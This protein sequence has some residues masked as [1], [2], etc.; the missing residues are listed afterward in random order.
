MAL[1]RNEE[2][3]DIRIIDRLQR[4]V[5]KEIK[6]PSDQIYNDTRQLRLISNY[7][8]QS[9]PFAI[10]RDYFDLSIVDLIKG[11]VYKLLSNKES[12]G[13]AQTMES[14]WDAEEDKLLIT[15]LNKVDHSAALERYEVSGIFIRAI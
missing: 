3:I 6:R 2:C 15:I 9:Y 5:V 10:I 13:Y 8:S 7:D 4:K 14:K 12:T 11:K 1:V